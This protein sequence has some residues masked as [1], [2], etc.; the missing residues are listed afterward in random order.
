MAIEIETHVEP[1]L[2][3]WT[4]VG[5]P[6]GAVRESKDRVWAALKNSGLPKPRGQITVNLAPADVRKEGS[7]FDLPLALGLLAASHG[8]IEQQVLDELLVLGEL[9]LDGSLRPVRGVLPMVVGAR[10]E[11]RRGV[12]VPA[13]N[14][15]EAAVVDGI[16]T[17]GVETLS[18]AFKLVTD[19]NGHGTPHK[20]NLKELFAE[21][22]AYPVDFAD[23][24]GQQHVKRAL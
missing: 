1:G 16:E 5:L 2:P 20:H 15:A 23:V 12:I 21:A 7:A 24:K 19:L 22:R 3:E 10:G 17:Y 4:V 9:S 14:A 18:D 11:G 8:L 13:V 6:N